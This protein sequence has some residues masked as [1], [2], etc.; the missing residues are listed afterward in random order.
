MKELDDIRF[1]RLD[2]VVFSVTCMICIVTC[3]C[4]KKIDENC[5]LGEPKLRGSE[6]G[7]VGI[8]GIQ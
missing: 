1:N 3:M 6:V 8:V 7:I 5:I 2:T 4:H